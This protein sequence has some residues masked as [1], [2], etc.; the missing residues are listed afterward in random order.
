MQGDALGPPQVEMVAT[1]VSS[2]AQFSLKTKCFPGLKEWGQCGFPLL[3]MQNSNIIVTPKIL[4]FFSNSEY[5]QEIPQSQTADNPMAP[6]GR[7]TQ[8]S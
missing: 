1:L 5:D 6:R 7:A 3:L 8:P 4:Y 2:L